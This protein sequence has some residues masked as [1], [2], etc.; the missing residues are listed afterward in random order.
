MANRTKWRKPYECVCGETDPDK[1][2]PFQKSQCLSCFR[3]AHN[4]RSQKPKTTQRLAM[5]YGGHVEAGKRRAP[6][7]TDG[8]ARLGRPPGKSTAWDADSLHRVT[9]PVTKVIPAKPCSLCG[10]AMSNGKCLACYGVR[11]PDCQAPILRRQSYRMRQNDGRMIHM[12]CD[13]VDVGRY[14]GE[15]IAGW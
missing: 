6:V 12:D 2:R 8:L 4:A 13:W 5:S 15:M 1:F 3:A 9:P 10:G 14:R 7:S 11:C